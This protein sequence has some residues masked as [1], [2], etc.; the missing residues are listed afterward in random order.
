MRDETWCGK[1]CYMPG[2]G[3]QEEDD[4]PKKAD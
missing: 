2:T 4:P 1:Y 3:E